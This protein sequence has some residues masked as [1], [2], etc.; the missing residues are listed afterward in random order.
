MTLSDLTDKVQGLTGPCRETDYLICETVHP[1]LA[2]QGYA[3]V[4]GDNGYHSA[5]PLIPGAEK[6]GPASEYTASLDAAMTLARTNR[7]AMLMIHSAFGSF[8]SDEMDAAPNIFPRIK[9]ML[10]TILR[11]RASMEEHRG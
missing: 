10:L 11:A 6:V 7:E 8:E 9:A 3:R 1:F 4:A 5:T 2:K